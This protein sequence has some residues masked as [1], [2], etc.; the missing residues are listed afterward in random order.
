MIKQ[1]PN[2]GKGGNFMKCIILAAGFGKRLYPLTENTPKAFIEVGGKTIIDSLVDNIN[3]TRRVDEYIIITNH[4][5]Y[6]MFY[7]WSFDRNENITV[8][9]DGVGDDSSSIGALNDLKLVLDKYNIEEDCIVT[10]ANLVFAFSLAAFFNFAQRKDGSCSLI[11]YEENEFKLRKNTV[12][13]VN[14]NDKVISII[15]KPA[16]PESYWICP[17]FFYLKAKDLNSVGDAIAS[18]CN[19]DS[20]GD[21]AC[22]IANN[23]ELY[24]MPVPGDLFRIT[25][26]ASLKKARKDYVPFV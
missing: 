22:Y 21:F 12:V 11:D 20:I 7:H 19:A 16:N 1:C 10:A 17:H 13:N 6:N 2:A 18:G 9:D 24:S 4:K 3:S 25:N 15:N 8:I 23:S 5:H 26:E 14:S